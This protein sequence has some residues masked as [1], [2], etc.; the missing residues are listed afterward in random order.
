[1]D[2]NRRELAILIPIAIMVIV[3]GVLPNIVLQ[4]VDRSVRQLISASEPQQP[5]T[6]PPN[7][8]VAGAR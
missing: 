2:L 4:S 5:Q 3:L 6:S 8:A 7:V 1:V